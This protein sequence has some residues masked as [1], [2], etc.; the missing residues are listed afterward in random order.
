MAALA[1]FCGYCVR[2]DIKLKDVSILE[3]NCFVGLLFGAMLPYAVC[4]FT[5][6]SVGEV[7][8]N[9][10]KQMEKKFQTPTG[11][12]VVNGEW[13]P[14]FPDEPSRAKQDE[15]YGGTIEDA[16]NDALAEIGW[17]AVIAFGTPVLV[18]TL[19]GKH[20][21]AGLCVGTIISGIQVALSTT[22]SGAAWDNAKKKLE[23][24]GLSGSSPHHAAIQGDTIGDPLRDASGPATNILMKL[25]P[26]VALTFAPI[27]ASIRHGYGFIGCSLTVECTA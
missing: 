19:M 25:M 12:T 17:P 22:N 16:A 5:M 1:G 21:L 11:R 6:K 24:E 13:D 9:I 18:G 2:C 8:Q 20:T 3:P 7:A 4:A 10:K 15:W 14:V 27:F 23:L 26:L